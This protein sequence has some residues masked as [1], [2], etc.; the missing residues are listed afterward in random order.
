MSPFTCLRNGGSDWDF[1]WKVVSTSPPRGWLKLN[2]T[3]PVWVRMWNWHTTGE[4]VKWCW[5]GARLLGGSSRPNIALSYDRASPALEYESNR[6]ARIRWSSRSGSGCSEQ[7]L[8]QLPNRSHTDAHST[9]YSY[10]RAL[11]R[12]ESGQLTNPTCPSGRF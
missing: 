6:S 7:V 9:A 2:L 8:W 3:Q 12:N 1:T 11:L 4:C 10:N 5:R